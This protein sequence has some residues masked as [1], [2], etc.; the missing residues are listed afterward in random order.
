MALNHNLPNSEEEGITPRDSVS[1]CGSSTSVS[2]R[3]QRAANRAT[4]RV[5]RALLQE[6]HALEARAKRS[7]REKEEQDEE[8]I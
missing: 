2:S 5:K 1:Q 3:A 6:R 7:E 8:A 4:A